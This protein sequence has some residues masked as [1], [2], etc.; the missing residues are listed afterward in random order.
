MTLSDDMDESESTGD[1]RGDLAPGASPQVDGSGTAEGLGTKATRGYLW[2]NVGILSRFGVA[3]VLASLLARELDKVEYSVMVAVTVVTLYTDTA[4]DLGMGAALIYEQEDGRSRRV[5]IAFTANIAFAV[6]LGIASVAAAPVIAALFNLDDY[7]A[8]FMVI[9]PLIVITGLNTVPWAL[10]TRDLDF[11]PRT[12]TELARD[13]SRLVVT[14]VMV[15]MLDMGIW[16]CGLGL[17]DLTSRVD[18]RH[19]GVDEVPTGPRLGG[20]GCQGAVR[21]RLAYGGEPVPRVACSQRRLLHRRQPDLLVGSVLPGLPLTRDRHGWSAQ[22]HVGGAVPHVQ[23]DSIQRPRGPLQ[24]HVPGPGPRC[25]V[26]D[27]C[28]SGPGADRP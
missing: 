4:L 27:S 7:V 21:I 15:M 12:Y 5:D 11:R 2:A 24:C 3:L 14:I 23:Q 28:G 13:G 6:L 8:V 26:L 16:G 22:R 1:E 17:P 19:L 25:A 9:G 20:A 10:L 18:R